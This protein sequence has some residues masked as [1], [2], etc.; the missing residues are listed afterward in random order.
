MHGRPY[1]RATT[2]PEN[3]IHIYIT[4]T[5]LASDNPVILIIWI[6]WHWR[7]VPKPEV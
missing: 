6:I 3:T 4:T 7:L 5:F 1:S 2:A